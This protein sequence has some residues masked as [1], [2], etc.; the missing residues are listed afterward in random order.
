MIRCFL[1]I[2]LPD[3]LRPQLALLQGELKK[4][5]ADVRW[6]AVGNIHLTLKFFGNVPDNEIDAITLAARE[7]AENQAPFQLQATQAGAFPSMKSPRVIWVGLGGDVIPLAQMYHKLEKAFEVLGHLP[8]GRPFNPHLTLGRV[9]SP[10]NR[11]RLAMALEKLPPL[12][13]PPFM[14][15]EIILFKSTLTPQGS[16]YSPLQVIPLGK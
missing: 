15:N 13:W 7:V 16:I 3:T 11:H 4:S 10:A 14:V 8:E 12:N 2:D 1:A 6:V 9:K 5:N